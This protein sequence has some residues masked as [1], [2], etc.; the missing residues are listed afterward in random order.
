MQVNIKECSL[1]VYDTSPNSDSY[2][3]HLRVPGLN[4]D[5][6]SLEQEALLFFD[7][8]TFAAP[9]VP[10][11]NGRVRCENQSPSETGT[12][13]FAYGQGL[14]L[15]RQFRANWGYT[16]SDVVTHR[17]NA[18]PTQTALFRIPPRV[19]QRKEPKPLG[20]HLTK[21]GFKRK[22][23]KPTPQPQVSHG[24]NLSFPRLSSLD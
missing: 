3:C 12:C 21:L 13:T 9:R 5:L 15:S 11:P 18:A 7:Q 1:G 17:I 20:K 22:T 23:N 4:D 14:T 10:L 8:S 2:E 16:I 19:K 6:V 24:K